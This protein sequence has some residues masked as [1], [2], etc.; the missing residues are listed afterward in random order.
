M[1]GMEGFADP[2]SSGTFACGASA[3]ADARLS[4]VAATGVAFDGVLFEATGFAGAGSTGDLDD[5]AI[6]AVRGASV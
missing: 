4:D 2:T 1:G 6:A 5:G 3:R